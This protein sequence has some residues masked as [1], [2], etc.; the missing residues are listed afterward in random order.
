MDYI[1]WLISKSPLAEDSS[2]LFPML[3]ITVFLTVLGFSLHPILGTLLVIFAIVF[4]GIIAYVF[5]SD[6]YKASRELYF[7][8]KK[9]QDESKTS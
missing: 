3:L 6:A 7:R 2:I 8:E 4:Y 5:I 9:K 1:R